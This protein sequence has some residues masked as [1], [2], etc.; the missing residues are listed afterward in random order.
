MQW[1]VV[2]SRVSISVRKMMKL[3]LQISEEGMYD[4]M[5]GSGII[6]HMEGN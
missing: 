6:F 3:T 2:D 1:N 5:N 4:L